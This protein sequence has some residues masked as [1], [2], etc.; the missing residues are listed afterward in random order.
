MIR[1]GRRQ[2]DHLHD[3][4]GRIAEREHLVLEPR[5]AIDDLDAEASEARAPELERAPRAPRMSL[6]RSA[7]PLLAGRNVPAL[8]G[9]RRPDR[10][11]RPDSSP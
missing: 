1:A 8:V 7:P 4:P 6:P 2:S 9:K 11:R 10:A 3:E 5:P